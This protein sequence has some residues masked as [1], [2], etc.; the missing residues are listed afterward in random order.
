MDGQCWSVTDQLSAEAG[1]RSVLAVGGAAAEAIGSPT[2]QLSPG[3][4]EAIAAVGGVLP[5]VIGH[6]VGGGHAARIGDPQAHGVGA[7]AP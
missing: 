3:E 5:A 4:G 7:A 1:Q 2:F 6:R